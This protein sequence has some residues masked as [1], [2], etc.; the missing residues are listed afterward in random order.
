LRKRNTKQHSDTKENEAKS[1]YSNNNIRMI[2]EDHS[3]QNDI[4][5]HQKDMINF[6][7]SIKITNAN[8]NSTGETSFIIKNVNNN[9]KGDDENSTRSSLDHR[10]AFSREDE[11]SEQLI[12]V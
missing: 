12:I 10:H 9:R 11:S 1:I 8:D 4:V 6:D 2:I 3:N 7:E 5:L